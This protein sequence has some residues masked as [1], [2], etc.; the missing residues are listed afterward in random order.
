M[1]AFFVSSCALGQ[2]KYRVSLLKI[3]SALVMKRSS[4]EKIGD[5]KK[6]VMFV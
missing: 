6:Q 3:D 2:L 4:L 5:I 1:I